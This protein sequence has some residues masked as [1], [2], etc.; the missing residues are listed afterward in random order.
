M[1]LPVLMGTSQGHALM[2]ALL[3]GREG[4]EVGEDGVQD[5][6]MCVVMDLGLCLMVT[7]LLLHV[8]MGAGLSAHKMTVLL[9]LKERKLSQLESDLG[10]GEIR[11][12]LTT[13]TNIDWI[14]TNYWV[15]NLMF[16]GLIH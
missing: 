11:N 12:N 14:H 8:L 2:G 6:T 10:K 1:G 15:W 4:G 13:K 16:W 7:G 9:G 3:P 5:L